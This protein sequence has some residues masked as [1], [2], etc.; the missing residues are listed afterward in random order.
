MITPDITFLY[1]YYL[2]MMAVMVTAFMLMCMMDPVT[3][4]GAVIGSADK[5]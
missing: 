2:S 3:R 4:L 5:R 1:S